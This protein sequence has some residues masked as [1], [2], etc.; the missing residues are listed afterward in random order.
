MATAITA[1][2]TT[3]LAQ[4]LNGKAPPPGQDK[5][6]ND[7]LAFALVYARDRRG[8]AAPVRT[9]LQAGADP[10]LT[11][12]GEAKMDVL[13]FMVLGMTDV[14]REIVRALLEHQADPNAV[15]PVN[16]GTPLGAV[17]GEPEVVRW[18]VEHGANIDALQN[19][20]VPAIVSFIGQQDWESAL[21]LI[22]KGANLDIRNADGLSVDY[23]LKDWKDTIY[24]APPPEGWDRV[25]AAIAARRTKSTPP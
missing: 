21:Y 2:D 5:A 10:R 12:V 3:T 23:Y 11:R 14:G 20:G 4:L 24:G 17:A 15:D 7:L 18:L 6:G 1:N 22:E 19:S 25:R 13:N 9:L 8:H 16:G